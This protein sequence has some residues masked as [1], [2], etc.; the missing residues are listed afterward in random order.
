[1][2]IVGL[3]ELQAAV[4]LDDLRGAVRDSL[5]AAAAGRAARPEVLHLVLGPDGG[6]VHVKAGWLEGAAT[7]T[8]KLAGH[9]PA[10]ADENLPP[11]QGLSLVC[12]ATTGAPGLLLLDGG[13]LTEARTAAAGAA[14]ID[15]L[16]PADPRTVA[17]LG[18][19]SQARHQAAA[20]LRVRRPARLVAW[21]RRPAAVAAL[22]SEL[23]AEHGIRLDVAATVREAVAGA[24]VVVTTTSARAPLLFERD[25]PET[26]LVI[27]VGADSPGKQ[28]LEGSLLRSAARLVVDDLEQCLGQ[29]ELQHAP[30]A[31]GRAVALG[32]LLSEPAGAAPGRTLVD[33]TGVGVQDAAAAELVRRGLAT[34]AG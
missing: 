31:A 25:L 22:A 28:E 29:G 12:D 16:A 15:H 19:G 17:L 5:I 9:F 1:M 6:E 4:N 18:A 30:D 14:A 20:L 23:R 33:L 32:A 21:A 3:P 2:R 7:F 11:H 34:T 10:A 24:D 8:V 13:W 26:V 27:A